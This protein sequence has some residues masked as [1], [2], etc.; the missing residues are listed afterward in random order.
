M[1]SIN[2]QALNID[3]YEKSISGYSV[4]NAKHIFLKPKNSVGAYLGLI[5]LDGITLITSCL[6][7]YCLVIE[8][9]LL[10]LY[11]NL[12]KCKLNILSIIYI[13]VEL[14]A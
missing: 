4:K 9:C 14:Q 1:S 11:S 5:D 12:V 2:S 7:A 6:A 3:V 8:G 10:M 13:G